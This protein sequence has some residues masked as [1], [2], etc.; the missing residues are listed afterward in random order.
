MTFFDFFFNISC[1]IAID[2]MYIEFDDPSSNNAWFQFLRYKKKLKSTIFSSKW[3]FSF[4]FFNISFHIA[5]GGMYTEFEDP[6]SNIANF[7][8]FVL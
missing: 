6:S 4:F 1:H 7:E 8:V 2:G 5:L 3:L